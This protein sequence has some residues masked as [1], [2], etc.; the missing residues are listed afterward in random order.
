MQNN[1]FVLIKKLKL[2]PSGGTS[3]IMMISSGCTAG[4]CVDAE[5]PVIRASATPKADKL[6]QWAESDREFLRMLCQNRDSS[7][8][9]GS[10]SSSSTTPWSASATP[11]RVRHDEANVGRQKYLRS[12]KFTRKEEQLTVGRRVMSQWERLKSRTN[13]IRLITP[14]SS[15][16]QRAFSRSN[17]NGHCPTLGHVLGFF[18]FCSPCLKA[19]QCLID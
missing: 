18:L 6:L 11:E 3:Q 9:D 16:H 7:L 15:H 2:V 8:V 13:R 14:N 10:G 17:Y 5:S 19:K 12:Y 4:G 1:H